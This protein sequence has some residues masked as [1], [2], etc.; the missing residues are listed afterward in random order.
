[1][2]YARSGELRVAYQA[3]G[4]RQA[5]LVWALENHTQLD[6]HWEL[7]YRVREFEDFSEFARLIVFDKRGIGLSDSPP[8]LT[9]EDRA[10]DIRAV[11]DAAGSVSAHLLGMYDGGAAAALFAASHPERTRSLIIYALR[12]SYL[13]D[14][15]YEFGSTREGFDAY[16]AQTEREFFPAIDPRA[17]SENWKRYVGR[18]VASDPSFW[19]WFE[20]VRRSTSPANRLAHLRL[21]GT[22]DIRAILPAIRVPTLVLVREHDPSCSVESARDLAERIPGA[23]FATL[24]G[25][26]HFW[27]DIWPE[28][29]ARL[30]EWV[31]G[32]PSAGGAGGRALTTMTFTDIVDSTKRVD[33]I[34]DLAWQNLVARYYRLARRHLAAYSG[35]EVDTSGDGLFAHFDGPSRAVRYCLALIREA[36]ALGLDV[37]AGAHT[38]EVEV[39]GRV[40]RGINVVMAARLGQ[41]AGAGEVVV[42]QTVRDLAAGSGLVFTSRGEAQLKGFNSPVQTYFASGA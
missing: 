38:G 23:Q 24:P 37:R 41:I 11:M 32:A 40:L 12:A 18:G 42:S 34:G 1:M 14:A 21:S 2:K 17:P 5:D 30:Q 9:Y 22:R 13:Q 27:F 15:N 4:D 20:R 8:V 31:T 36:S 19:E 26:G 35:E 7:P 33:T 25:E 28:V 29:R 39:V 6:L 10:D 3:I 16:V